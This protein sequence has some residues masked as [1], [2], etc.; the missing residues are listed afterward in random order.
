MEKWGLDENL[1]SPITIDQLKQIAKRIH[2]SSLNM[3]KV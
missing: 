1:I 3:K 2:G